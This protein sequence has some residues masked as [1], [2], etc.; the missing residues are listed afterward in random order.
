MR[1]LTTLLDEVY[2]GQE[3][4]GPAEIHRRAL[5]AGASAEV[6]DALDRLPEGEYTQD[7]LVEAIGRR[8]AEPD[9]ADG[10]G[11]P[12]E[13]LADED[14]MRELATIHRT[15]HDALR[16]GSDQALANHDERM[17]ELERGYL[18][19]YPGREIDPQRLTEGAR[20]RDGDPPRGSAPAG[21]GFTA[22]TGAEQPWDPAK[23]P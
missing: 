12:A 9:A 20:A 8:G 18:R 7:E 4:V 19:R 11:I 23:T 16:H 3:R 6:L 13:R 14:L 2:A 1:E 5:A 22:R 21:N 15:R 10:A 17:A